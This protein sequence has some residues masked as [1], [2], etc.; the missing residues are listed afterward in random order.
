MKLYA[1]RNEFQSIIQTAIDNI[2]F[3][4]QSNLFETAEK[5]LYIN[6]TLIKVMVNT[7][8][9]ILIK[10]GEKLLLKSYYNFSSVLQMLPNEKR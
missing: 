5:H 3:C 9:T 4:F 1:A 10:L 6:T 7:N 8:F 2:Y